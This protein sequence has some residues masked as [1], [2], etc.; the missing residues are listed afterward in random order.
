MYAACPTSHGTSSVIFQHVNAIYCADQE[1]CN[2]ARSGKC[3]AC[4]AKEAREEEQKGIDVMKNG[5]MKGG[6]RDSAMECA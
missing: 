3:S 6:R 1:T 4:Q 5:N 2:D